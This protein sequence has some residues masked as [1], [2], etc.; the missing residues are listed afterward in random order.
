MRRNVGETREACL[1][2]LVEAVDR[3]GAAAGQCYQFCPGSWSGDLV[4][5]SGL[6]KVLVDRLAQNEGGGQWR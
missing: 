4:Y 6:T 2:E 5:W 1:R 3:V